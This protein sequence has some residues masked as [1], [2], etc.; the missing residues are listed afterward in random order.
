M[1]LHPG[2]SGEF[3]KRE[4]IREKYKIQWKWLRSTLIEDNAAQDRN[5]NLL[6]NTAEWTLSCW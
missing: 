3:Q 6:L 1:L 4:I 5:Q 2:R